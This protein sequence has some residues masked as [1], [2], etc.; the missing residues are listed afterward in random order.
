MSGGF[1]N[2]CD[3]ILLANLFKFLNKI[4]EPVFAEET[5]ELVVITVKVYYTL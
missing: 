5:T 3:E 1:E 2:V 4:V